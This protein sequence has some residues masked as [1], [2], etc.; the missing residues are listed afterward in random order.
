MGIFTYI[1][2]GGAIA[3]FL[4]SGYFVLN[5]RHLQVENRALKA[6]V[7]ALTRVAEIYEQ[8]ATTDKEITREKDR[9]D[10]LTPE[11]LDSEYKRLLD[12]GSGEGP[13][14]RPPKD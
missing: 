4:V 14:S 12:Y 2:I 6:E 7:V 1:K 8:D 3:L 9:V 13:N 5:Y 10:R 11:Q